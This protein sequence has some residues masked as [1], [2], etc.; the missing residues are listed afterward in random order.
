[1]AEGGGGPS[2]VGGP[3]REEGD[4]TLSIITH[5]HSC[6]ESW[7]CSRL[8]KN[9][10]VKNAVLKAAG[11]SGGRSWCPACARSA[12]DSVRTRGL[13]G[14]RAGPG[15]G[16]GAACVPVCGPGAWPLPCDILVAIAQGSVCDRKYFKETLL[17]DHDFL[18]N[19]SFRRLANEREVS[20]LFWKER[21]L[22]TRTLGPEGNGP[23]GRGASLSPRRVRKLPLPGPVSRQL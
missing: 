23:A 13:L 6:S 20:A 8:F 22:L 15:P 7:E 12:V 1:M 9:I 19:V 17:P 11:R 3:L 18:G 16:L 4:S 14:G 21:V 2:G 5:T 10:T